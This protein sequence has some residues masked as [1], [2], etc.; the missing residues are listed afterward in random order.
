MSDN[1]SSNDNSS[2]ST[3]E[4]NDDSDVE[5]IVNPHKEELKQKSRTNNL[6]SVVCNEPGHGKKFR[7]RIKMKSHRKVYVTYK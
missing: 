3:E 2:S 5:S 4:D 6:L 1:N 7:V